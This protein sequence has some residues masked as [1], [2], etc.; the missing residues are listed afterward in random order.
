MTTTYRGVLLLLVLPV[1]AL[2]LVP[3]GAAASVPAGVTKALDYLNTRQRTDGGFSY[4]SAR[5][6]AS[7]TPWAMLA[8]A[9]GANNPAGWKVDARSPVSFLQA[10]NLVAAA[11][12][13]GNPPEYYALCIL[14][15]L[16]ADRTDLLS[17]AGSGQIDLVA[18]LESYQTLTGGYYSPTLG[19]ATAAT[20]TTA[21]AVLGLVAAHQSGTSLSGAV[22]WL[23]KP[24]AADGSGGG[25]NPDGGFGTQPTAPSST[26][27]TSLVVQALVAGRVAADG[28]LVQSAA[29]FITTMQTSGGGFHDIAGGDP[30][31]PSTAWAIEG[32]HA[33]GVSAN[34]VTGGHTPYTFLARLRQTNGSYNEFATDMGDVMNSTLQAAIA[35]SGATLPV[36]R[37]ANVVT[38]FA[39]SFAGTVLP[40]SGARYAGSTVL[41][42]AAYH[43]NTNGTGIHTAAVRLT[44]DGKSRTAAAHITA[45]GLHLE[46][47]R[48]ANGAHTYLI[49]VR[50]HAGNVVLL[51][52]TF[53]VAVPTSTGGGT[54]PGSG[55]TAP[56]GGSSNTGTGSTGTVHHTATLTPT[57]TP[58][59]AATISPSPSVLPGAT[60]TP[61]PSSSLPGALVT[62]SPS[63][64][65][66]GQVSGSGGSGGGTNTSALVGTT[67]AALVPLGFFGSWLVRRRLIGVMD[68]ASRGEILPHES[69]VWQRFWKSSGGQPPAGGRE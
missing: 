16:A 17:N 22:D 60:L 48:L 31:A 64:S 37:S 38:R 9:A 27:I 56:K 1:V 10:T 45:S 26:T 40:R 12:D 42:K 23:Q 49:V 66:T 44:V 53:T 63:A 57:P 52:R 43:D 65:I 13:S 32:L 35:L 14:A 18:K 19:A 25:P 69:S 8:I 47:T 28:A 61:T 29:H 51:R 62:P 46:L 34:Q 54:H 20:E 21:W 55:T 5:G 50:D 41:V 68:G 3:A 11:A 6:N 24:A 39:P 7:D 67:L 2:L 15:Y 4:S 36:H 58:T 30:S 33:A 59:P